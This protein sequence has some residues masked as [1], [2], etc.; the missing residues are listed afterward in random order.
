MLLLFAL[1]TD[2]ACELETMR[3]LLSVLPYC[4]DEIDRLFVAVSVLAEPNDNMTI[5]DSVAFWAICTRKLLST[6]TAKVV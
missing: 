3:K 5:A 4:D 1:S 2:G 6:V